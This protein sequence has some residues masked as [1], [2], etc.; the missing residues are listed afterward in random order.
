MATAVS[1]HV[2][3]VYLILIQCKNFSL[4]Y[5]KRNYISHNVNISELMERLDL[6]IATFCLVLKEAPF[7]TLEIL[8]RYK[9]SFQNMLQFPSLHC[10][11]L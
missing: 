11:Y 8:E 9:S 7:K 6:A 3:V 5:Y 2:C 10:K 1:Q 4:R